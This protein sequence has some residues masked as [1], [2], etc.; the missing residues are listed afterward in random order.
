MKIHKVL[1]VVPFAFGTILSTSANEYQFEN[2]KL[3]QV[4]NAQNPYQ[5]KDKLVE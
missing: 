5:P 3:N 1:S 2:N 4:E